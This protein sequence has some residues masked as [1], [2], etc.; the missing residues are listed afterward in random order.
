ME[1]KLFTSINDLVAVDERRFYVTNDHKYRLNE[2][3]FI[4]EDLIP[5]M[6]HSNLLFC[7]IDKEC[8][9]SISPGS[10]VFL[11][12]VNH[13]PFHIDNAKFIYL[14]STGD[15][16]IYVYQRTIFN[17]KNNNNNIDNIDNN[18]DDG[19][20]ELVRKIWVNSG[21]DNIIV[22]QENGSL[23]IGSHPNS[24]RFLIHAKD[25]NSPAPSHV[26]HIINPNGD[27]N[28]LKIEEIYLSNG[29]GKEDI[30]ASSTAARVGDYLIITPVFDDHILLCKH[31]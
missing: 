1:S 19:K 13:S 7:E 14:S 6:S 24:L 18:I 22:D 12:G 29:G 20:L 2:L 26:I 27:I 25:S 28:N 23:W 15:K 10:H 9:Y 21:V 16:S 31:V 30:S 8:F 11:N 4:F 5:K 17:K 3:L